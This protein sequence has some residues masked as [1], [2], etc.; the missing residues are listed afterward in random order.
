M[1]PIK[2]MQFKMSVLKSTWI[3]YGLVNVIV[4]AAIYYFSNRSKGVV[5]L[6]DYTINIA[7]TGV[8]LSLICSG[9]V[10]LTIAGMNKKGQIPEHS[11]D[12]RDHLIAHFL[13]KRT[14]LQLIAITAMIT[15]H[16]TVFGTGLC[17]VCG[18]SSEI[19]V[20]A[21]SLINGLLCGMMGMSNVYLMYVARLT[22]IKALSAV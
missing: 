5:R 22:S 3:G 15:L 19:P 12:R 20:K 1:N 13:P 11:Y 14:V 17:A 4:N 8:I 9:F 10:I 16:F 2:S 7:I 18:F 6:Q 21:A